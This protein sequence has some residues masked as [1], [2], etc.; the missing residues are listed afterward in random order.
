M[1]VVIA[2]P[3]KSE[4]LARQTLGRTRD[5]DTLYIELVDL[6]FKQT[7][8]YYY[9]KLHI[10]NKYAL[11]TSDTTIDQYELDKRSEILKKKQ[12]EKI[13]KSPFVLHD[14]RFFHYNNEEE[15]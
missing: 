2:E 11:T 3:F 10:F 12:D 9:S 5:K 13:S 14:E 15:K 6:G 4:V 8:N 7:R 1:T